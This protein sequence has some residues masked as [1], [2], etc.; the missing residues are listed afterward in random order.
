MKTR[1]LLLLLISVLLLCSN[2][3][4]LPDSQE[5]FTTTITEND[6]KLFNFTLEMVLPDIAAINQNH[7]INQPNKQQIDAKTL[8]TERFDRHY[9]NL[10]ERLTEHLQTK[11][12]A[13]G[14]CRD[15]YLE[16]GRIFRKYTATIRGEC[17]EDA[18]ASDRENFASSP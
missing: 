18:T 13:T 10:D 15:G 11:L 4:T 3:S 14:Y 6:S 9:E 5:K 8:E 7:T 17:N 1:N 16:L 12:E 2:C